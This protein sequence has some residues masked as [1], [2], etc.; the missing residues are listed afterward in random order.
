MT[1]DADRF[2][3][4]IADKLRRAEGFCVPSPEELQAEL[5]AI[6]AESL[7]EAQIEAIVDAAVSGELI[8]W[9]SPD[10]PEWAES[11]ETNRIREDALQLNRNPGV[12][13]EDPETNQLLE[14]QRREALGTDGNLGQEQDRLDGGREASGV[15]D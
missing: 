10:E 12:P 3:D 15:G 9:T 13:E 1:S 5:D 11:G 6:E 8:V 7:T 14:Q 2:W 4:Q